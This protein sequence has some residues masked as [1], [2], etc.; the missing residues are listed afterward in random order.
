MSDLFDLYEDN[1]NETFNKIKNITRTMQNLSKE[2]TESAINEANS[3]IQDA[4]SLIKKLELEATTSNNKDKLTMKIK[5]YKSEFSNLKQTFLRLQTNYINAKSNEALYLNSDDINDKN[6]VDN[7][8]LVAYH[9]SS[10]L[11]KALGSVLEIDNRGNEIMR[12]LD[13][14][15]NVMNRVNDNLGDMNFQLADSN[16]LLGKMM[17]RENRNKVIIL[18]AVIF[19]TIVLIIIASALASGGDDD[20]KKE[21]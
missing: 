6:L 12:Q 13:H 8:E 14:Q 1:L 3:H 2:K 20:S 5:N 7:E 4:Q 18:L 10:K 16:S 21:S 9:Q 15:T 17:R 19:F 11:D